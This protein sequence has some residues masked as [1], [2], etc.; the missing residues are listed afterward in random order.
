L[1][2]IFTNLGSFRAKFLPEGAPSFLNPFLSVVE[3]I[4]ILVR[5]LTLSIRLVANINAGHLVLILCRG[6]CNEAFRINL[7][8][9]FFK[10]VP[11]FLGLINVFYL[12]F[13]F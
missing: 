5:P 9:R 12:I 2:R 7:L 1:S 4:S 6:Y 3:F 11:F 13:D 10:I 8:E